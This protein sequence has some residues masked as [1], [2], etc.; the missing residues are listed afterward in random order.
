MTYSHWIT[1]PW[2]SFKDLFPF[3]DGALL[4]STLLLQCDQFFLSRFQRPDS[5]QATKAWL[6]AAGP[7]RDAFGKTLGKTS[8]T[9]NNWLVVSGTW[10]QYFP[11]YIGNFIIP[12]DFH[13][14]IFQRGS[15]KPP[16]SSLFLLG[17]AAYLEMVTMMFMVT[18]D[19]LDWNSQSRSVPF[20][21]ICI[22]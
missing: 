22:V 9:F 17:T 10:L 21:S 19:D 5:E 4:S 11:Q 2:Y 3:K 8:F 13:S 18:Y 15:E 12:T 7:R 14:I 1:I 16:T 6:W 20:C